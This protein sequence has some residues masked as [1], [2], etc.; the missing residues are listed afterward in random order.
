MRVHGSLTATAFA[1]AVL[2]VLAAIVACQNGETPGPTA[3]TTTVVPAAIRSPAPSASAAPRNAAPRPTTDGTPIGIALSFDEARA[4][5]DVRELAKPEYMGRHTGTPGEL[6]GAQYLAAQFAEVGLRPGGDSGGFLQTFQVTVQELASVPLLELTG[7]SGERR[8]LRLRDDFRPIVIGPAGA[9]DVSGEVIF[10]GSGED[11]SDLD[12]DGRLLL[13]VPRGSLL[14]IV[15]RAR[16]AGAIGVLITTGRAELLKAEAQPPDANALPMVELSQAGAAALLE[17][18]AHTREQLNALIARDAALPTF[19]LQWRARLKVDLAPAATID[20]H[21]VVAYLPAAVPTTRSIVIGGHYEEIGP[22]PD[23]VVFPAANDNA[24]GTAVVLE[25]ARRLAE[26]G[27]APAVNIVFIGWSGHEE[28]LHGSAYYVQH[29]LF[30]VA[31]GELYINVDTVGQGGGPSLSVNGSARELFEAARGLLAG[32]PEP[33]AIEF[34]GRSGGGSDDIAFA[35]A[36]MPTLA[37]AWSGVFTGTPMIHTPADTAAGVDPA[38]VR[39]TGVLVT[40]LAV[41]AAAAG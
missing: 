6:L 23:G 13:I 26:E 8:S 27:I 31:D 35:G 38:K 17:G 28:G 11:L 18:S 36:G 2:V 12:L 15:S 4:M 5:A 3:T 24:S 33:L 41:L 14:D 16:R 21:N 19:P 1:V 40:L 39:T 29:P 10:G 22:D 37:L 9:G 25:V 7:A 32:Q 30:P 34:G 20:A